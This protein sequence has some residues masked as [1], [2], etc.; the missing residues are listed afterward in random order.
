MSEFSIKFARSEQ[1]RCANWIEENGSRGPYGGARLGLNDWYC[2]EFLMNR[3]IGLVG[4][5]G[6]GKDESAKILG[7]FGYIRIAFADKLK[8]EVDYAILTNQRPVE[9]ESYIVDLMDQ[10]KVGDVW[11]KPTKPHVRI[12]LQHWGTE[13][14][15]VH[16]GQDYWVDQVEKV[17]RANEFDYFV[18]SDAR[19]ENE[20]DMVR[21]LGGRV[22]KIEREVGEVGIAGHVSETNVDKLYY[23][24]LICNNGTLEDLREAVL[25]ALEGE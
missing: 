20:V 11:E 19:F 18:I 24:R 2:E 13:Y 8:E 25:K 9:L 6:V 3:L 14:R 21:R 5:A 1:L 12:V 7:N 22:F 16:F 4:R 17:I 23:D 15:R 10:M